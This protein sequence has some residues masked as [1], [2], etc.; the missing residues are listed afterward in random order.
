MTLI[1]QTVQDRWTAVDQY[2][3]D[4]LFPSDAV[5]AA[6]L[7]SST[8]AGLP[9]I[10]VTASQGKLLC[11]LAQMSGAR[12]ILEIGTL[13]GYSTLW[14]ARAL[15]ADGRIITLESEHRHAEVAH[16]N[17]ARAGMAEKIE[18][19]LGSA[20][21]T[22][23]QLVAEKHAPFDFIFLD[24]NKEGYPEYLTW[25]LRLSHP[26]TIIVADNVVR[27]GE[28][29]Y[30][31][32]SNIQVQGARRFNQMLASDSRVSATILQTVGSKGYDGFA[33]ARV[34]STG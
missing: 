20:Q 19:R 22:L 13:G 27:D 17:F 9:P 3:D 33:L 30:A 32:S 24:A 28:V 7:A 18:L 5:L 2:I 6:A 31:D 15:P 21:E 26:G 4:L 12:T 29:I 1:P 10:S 8:A 14:L 25:S 23:P 11:L 34:L 16:G